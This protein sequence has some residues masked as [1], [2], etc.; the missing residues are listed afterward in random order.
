M[1]ASSASSQGRQAAISAAFGFWWM[2][3][4]AGLPLEVLDDVRDVGELAVD[5]RLLERP[6]EQ[7]AGGADE[8][9]AGEILLVAGLLADEHQLGLGPSLAEDGL[10]AAA[11]EVARSA[12]LRRVR[13]LAEGR[14][15]RDQGGGGVSVAPE[16]RLLAHAG[17]YHAR[18]WANADPA[19]TIWLAARW[20]S[21]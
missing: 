11:P 14:I 3:R 13:E 6:V 21:G 5:A 4:P 12:T 1:S 8:R 2:R 20:P 15:R 9:P 10:R 19:D 17:D 16:E 18:A 7:L